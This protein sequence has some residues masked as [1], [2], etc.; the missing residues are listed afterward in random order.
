[1]KQFAIFFIVD[2]NNI[3]YVDHENSTC[4]V[5][6]REIDAWEALSDARE[7]HPDGDWMIMPASVTPRHE[8]DEEWMDM[9]LPYNINE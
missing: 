1:M 7:A 3:E 6:Y 9:Y 2:R 5:V 8:S 4:K